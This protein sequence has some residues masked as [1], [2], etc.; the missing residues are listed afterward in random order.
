MCLT[1]FWLLVICSSCSMAH[2][3]MH[4]GAAAERQGACLVV[5]GARSGRE[6]LAVLL[7][8]ITNRES[9]RGTVSVS[10]SPHIRTHSPWVSCSVIRCTVLVFFPQSNIAFMQ[11]PPR[12]STTPNQQ[13]QSHMVC[14]IVSSWR[15]PETS[16]RRGQS[17]VTPIKH[18]PA[19]SQLGGRQSVI[20][21]RAHTQPERNSGSCGILQTKPTILPLLS[22]LPSRSEREPP[23]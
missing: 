2:S 11:L 22:V 13:P 20:H 5:V 23:A 3:V 19:R 12:K 7:V 9:G 6:G 4:V 21:S 8:S 18:T 14:M 16:T 15:V 1:L 10:L 17:A